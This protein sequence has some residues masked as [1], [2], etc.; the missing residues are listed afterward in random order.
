MSIERKDV[1]A[2]LD[3]ELHTALKIFADI[4][5]VTE[6]QFIEDIVV[7][8]LLRRIADATVAAE[9]LTSAGIIGKNRDER[10]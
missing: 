8:V 6:A 4:D 5:G 2:K 1:R 3:P 10:R 9:K 7:P